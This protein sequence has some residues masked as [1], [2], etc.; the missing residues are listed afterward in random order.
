MKRGHL[1]RELKVAWAIAVKDMKIYYLR[2]PSLM[3]GILFPFSMFL[4]FVIGRNMPVCP[5]LAFWCDLYQDVG[6]FGEVS[7]LHPASRIHKADK[8][9]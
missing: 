9:C 5:P 4:S 2:T 1:G 3:F 7:G 6:S 8:K